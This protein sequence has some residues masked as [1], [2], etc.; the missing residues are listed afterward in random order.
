MRKTK[1]FLALLLC[2]CMVY[3]LLGTGVSA[4]TAPATSGGTAAATASSDSAAAAGGPSSGGGAATAKASTGASSSKDLTD[5]SQVKHQAAVSLMVKL[6]LINGMVQTDNTV[7]YNPNDNLTRAQM[8]KIISVAINLVS[9]KDAASDASSAA[10]TDVTGHWAA[11][12]I[13]T[14]TGSGILNGIG[15]GKFNPDGTVTVLETAKMLLAAMGVSGLTG[16]SWQTAT[17]SAAAKYSLLTNFSGDN[18]SAITR[19]NAAQLIYNAL[20]SASY[21][22]SGTLPNV[23][24][25]SENTTKDL[26]VGSNTLVTAVEGKL[27]TA[28]QN[29]TEIAT[30]IPG[31][32][33]NCQ[34]VI[35]DN[36]GKIGSFGGGGTGDYDFR[37]GL[38][39][40]KDGISQSKSVTSVISGGTYD[41]TTISG[42]TMNS[43][44]QNF[45]GIIVNG[46]KDVTI[47]DST[48][49]FL[50]KSDGSKVNDFSGLGAV[51]S[52][53]NGAKVTLDN[54]KITTSGVARLSSFTDDYATTVIKNS[55][56]NVKG[57]TVYAGYVNS[58]DQSSMVAP[59]WVLGITGNA[60]G[61]NLEGNYS[62]TVVLNS[63]V[64]ANQW[65][66]V[67][68]D[69]G[70]NMQ[71]YIADSTLTLK[72]DGQTKDP[73]SKNYGSGYGTYAIGNAQEFFYGDTINAGT[74]A[75]IFTGGYATYASSKGTLT[76]YQ[77]DSSGK[78]ADFLGAQ[79]PA[80]TSTALAS[81]TGK[82]NKTVINSDAFGFM[83]HGAAG[84]NVTDGTIVNTNNAAFLLKVGGANIHVTDGAQINVKDGV[85][86]Q[87]MDND[88]SLVGVA[89]M[90]SGG[91]NFN[92]SYHETAGWHEGTGTVSGKSP[93]N[94]YA[95]NVTL[96]GN[97]YNG[98]GNY[99]ISGM[100]GGAATYTGNTL[101]LTL[102]K[103]AILNGA[104]ASTG[105]KHVDENGKQNTDFTIDQYYYLGHLA[106]TNF[107]NGS[108]GV[109]VTMKDG[110][111][112]NV[113]GTSLLTK[114]VVD[115]AANIKAASGTLTVTVD[116]KKV[117]LED[118]KTYTGTI[119]IADQTLQIT[120]LDYDTT[121]T[122]SQ[123]VSTISSVTLQMGGETKTIAVDKTKQNATLTVD[124]VEYNLVKSYESGAHY[125]YTTAATTG[126]TLTTKGDA[127]AG[128]GVKKFFHGATQPDSIAY[129]FDAGAWVTAQGLQKDYSVLNALSGGTTDSKSSTGTTIVSKG[130]FFNGYYITGA[131]YNISNLNMTLL[132]NG[133]DDFQGWGAGIM[134]T[135]GA[136]V[137]VDKSV[138]DTT[139][140]VR[141]AI[142]AGGKNATL[143]VTNTVVTAHNND[144]ATPY[145]DKDNYAVPML[146]R[147]PFSLGLNG[148]IRATNVLGSATAS[149]TDSIVVSNV[150]G[151]LS[152]D[153]GTEGTKALD[154]SNVLSGIGTV[155]VAQSGKTYTA[156]KDVNGVKYGFTIGKLGERSGYVTYADAGV[157]DIFNNDSFYA[158]DYIGIIASGSS[159]MYMNNSYGYSNRTGFLIHQN[160]GTVNPGSG[161]KGGLYVKGGSYDVAD[162][163]VT[164]KG[165][166]I[167]GSYTKTNVNVD[168]AKINLFGTAAQSGV[169]MRLMEADDA[170]NPGVT[171]YTIKDATY[172]EYQAYKVDKEVDPTTATFAN[173]T[174]KGDIFNS[175]YKVKQAL[176]VT[177][178]K[179]TLTGKI[180]SGVQTHVDASGKAFA[181]TIYASNADDYLYIGRVATEAHPAANNPVVLTV[182]N[183][184]TWNVTGTSYLSSLTF[185]ATS[186]INGT[187]TVDGKVVTT[188]GT[189]TGNV[190]VTAK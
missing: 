122:D 181:G 94:F 16:S 182:K 27:V 141:T 100:G 171:E 144:S 19:D 10:F 86:L 2:V 32:Y 34:L 137:S 61:T 114:L 12:Y 8:A 135:D 167:N 162:S 136:N 142:W 93:V 128:T 15:N 62:S 50:S 1:K 123:A 140:T 67:S 83:A 75:T 189:Y 45:N 41:A 48:F 77:M 173:M 46:Q 178:D 70:Q 24:V 132:G 161:D 47:K 117:A 118:G 163:F 78:T 88:D 179:M 87:M 111:V 113:T 36:Y 160:Q 58:A 6:G 148:D 97:F 126:I 102:G 35:T 127:Q 175:V 165:G 91:P 14:C 25:F 22:G 130:G 89:S 186:T 56:I 65:G 106:N 63:N 55:E 85:I 119:V 98:S 68:T 159:A 180:T 150:W 51:V 116:G 96:N 81:V 40:D 147:T 99:A 92:T 176:N 115:K 39:I 146:E 42:I 9:K 26:T 79:I 33:T 38:Y 66:V 105:V 11:K 145:S 190:V 139:G 133:G 53:F 169:L 170:G 104:A 129:Y 7:K 125:A 54:D 21:D 143:K 107:Y 90:G 187:I 131:T 188:P 43:T 172:A 37:A 158:P 101:Q 151:A 157:Y 17:A 29:G 120:G 73:Y 49:N 152:T 44:S 164:V 177:L 13:G 80:F 154:V 168:G 174:V 82:G 57:G 109:E 184:T 112:W 60:R 69:A 23:L 183:S 156:T 28:I 134:A 18:N 121:A 4:A 20:T 64:T 124:G 30:D 76:A 185:D 110:A 59:P 166:S 138:I 149:Y 103:G 108:N 52:S 95:E 84:I 3:S 153:S 71:L 5:F 155:E 74:Y 31:T 72:G